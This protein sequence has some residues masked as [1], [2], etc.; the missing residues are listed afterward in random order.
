MRGPLAVR[1][2]QH[3]DGSASGSKFVRGPDNVQRQVSRY[4]E[5]EVNDISLFEE[6]MYCNETRPK[7][8]ERGFFN[9]TDPVAEGMGINTN[10]EQND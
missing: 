7:K 5:E 10:T 2:F 1:Y 9:Y 8:T 6:Q 4:K 3:L